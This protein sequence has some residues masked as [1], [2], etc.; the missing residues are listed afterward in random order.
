MDGVISACMVALVWS[1]RNWE[2]LLYVS[3][4]VSRLNWELA[5]AMRREGIVS[6]VSVRL[7]CV[8]REVMVSPDVSVSVSSLM[9]A[10]RLFLE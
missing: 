9:V 2:K 4:K 6:I 7:S 10:E 5:V 8:L 3:R 1:L